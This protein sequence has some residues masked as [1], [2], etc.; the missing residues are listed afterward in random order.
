MNAHRL[1]S[2][3]LTA[4][5]LAGTLGALGAAPASAAATNTAPLLNQWKTAPPAWGPV[6]PR[7]ASF[8]TFR[9]FFFR[10]T[11]MQGQTLNQIAARFRVSSARLARINGIANPN[12]I[13]TGMPLF[14]PTFRSFRFR[15]FSIRAY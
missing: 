4:V 9:P 14:V 5:L 8:R 11:V 12:L 2:F 13:A 7:S 3:A 6:V 15:P 10:I 1:L